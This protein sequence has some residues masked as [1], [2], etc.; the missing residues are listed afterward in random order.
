MFNTA[1]LHPMIVHFPIALIIVGFVADFA[2]L[3]FRKERCLT[4]MGFYLMILGTLAAIVA[5]ATGYFFTGEMEGEPGIVR[6]THE[7]WAFT[8]LVTVIVSLIFRIWIVIRKKEESPLKF[9]SLGL[10]FLAFAFVS[11]TGYIGGDLV[12][13]Y[14]LGM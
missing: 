14:L 6:D 8:T 4:T 12:M 1:H 5:V 3:F 11:I 7:M 13:T 9:I 2:G 10:Y